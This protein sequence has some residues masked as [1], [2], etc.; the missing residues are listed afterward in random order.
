VKAVDHD[1]PDIAVAERLR[2]LLD[3]RVSLALNYLS[4]A[5]VLAIVVLMVVKP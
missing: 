1:D 3:D 2:L 5:L 4:A